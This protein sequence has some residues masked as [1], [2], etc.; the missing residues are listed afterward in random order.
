MTRILITGT[1]QG[2][3]F[4]C[5]KYFLKDQNNFVY[6]V[7]RNISELKKL[8]GKNG[9]QLRGINL[10]IIKADIT[11]ETDRRKILNQ[12][13]KSGKQ[14]DILI[15][16]AGYLVNKPFQEISKI[17]LK[18]IYETN[19]FAP[20]NLTQKFIPKMNKRKKSH[21]INIGS[22]GGVQGSLKFAGLSAYSSSKMALAGITECLAEEF[23]NTNI[24]FNCL[25]LGAVQTEML[26][27][28]FPGY[29]AKISAE[30]IAKCICDFAVNG[31][32]F[33]NGRIIEVDGTKPI[34][35]K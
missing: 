5:V 20:F 1:S 7:S 27:K 4:E 28:A 11:K 2:I 23:K 33:M 14:I 12:I 26:Q 10:E 17:D 31:H 3:G 25:A 9:K 24:G 29:K 13:S 18:K 8:E 35:L 16:N 32:H 21:I 6:A 30:K 22:I 34:E 19:V 15:H